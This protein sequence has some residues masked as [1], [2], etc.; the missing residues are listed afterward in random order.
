MEHRLKYYIIIIIIMIIIMIIIIIYN[1]NILYLLEMFVSGYFR[2]GFK[3]GLAG[4][5]MIMSASDL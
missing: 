2:F 1:N 3:M 5:R 4:S